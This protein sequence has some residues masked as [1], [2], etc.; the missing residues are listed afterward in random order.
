MRILLA[1]VLVL[2]AGGCGS[3]TTV[4]PTC[5]DNVVNGAETD[6]DCG[7]AICTPCNTGKRCSIDKDCRSKLCNSDAVCSAPSC[8]DGVVNGSESDLDCGGPDC[9]PCADGR[10]CAGGNDC[11]SHVCT[12]ATCQ[13]P[14]CDDGFRN[15]DELAV[16]CGGSCPPCDGAAGGATD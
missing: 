5:G 11:R 13:A 4:Y 12:G 7:G 2:S 9:G 10:V 3:K 14:S 1:A 6:V 15:G 16:D 8:S